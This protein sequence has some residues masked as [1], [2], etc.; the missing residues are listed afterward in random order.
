QEAVG[1]GVPH[2]A[3]AATWPADGL[4]PD[5]SPE[6]AAEMR[7]LLLA[8]VALV[9]GTAPGL[10]ADLKP[11]RKV[12][13]PTG[14]AMPTWAGFYAGPTLGWATGRSDGFYQGTTPPGPAFPA[15]PVASLS[16]NRDLSQFEG[17]PPNPVFQAVNY[18]FCALT[19]PIAPGALA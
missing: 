5:T 9:V 17:G 3:K 12:A 7:K 14:P 16:C 15:P 19:D 6:G 1:T 11:V 18:L 13:A 4:M 8:S 2:F 10:S